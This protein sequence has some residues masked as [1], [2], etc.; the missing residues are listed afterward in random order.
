[1]LVSARS[2]ERVPAKVLFLNYCGWQRLPACH[3]LVIRASGSQRNR[4]RSGC[5]VAAAFIN[6]GAETYAGQ[7]G[8]YNL[9][10][11]LEP[12]LSGVERA[13]SII[14]G[15]G[16]DRV[17]FTIT[18]LGK[19]KPEPA[20]IKKYSRYI[21]SIEYL[22]GEGNCVLLEKYIFHYDQWKRIWG[23]DYW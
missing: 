23:I 8:K 5:V 15:C 20:P 10:V 2:I 16:R 21:G 14:I 1:M 13:A 4:N 17:G 7:A 6:G 18:Q 3:L 9:A 19:N 11:C 12:N 22:E